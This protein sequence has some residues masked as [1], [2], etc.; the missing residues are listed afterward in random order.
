MAILQRYCIECGEH[1]GLMS[2]GECKDIDCKCTDCNA[3]EIF[4]QQYHLIWY[5]GV[6]HNQYIQ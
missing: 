2:L 4:D 1:L 5:G 3:S 6:M